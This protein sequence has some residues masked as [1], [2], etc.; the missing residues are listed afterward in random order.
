[1]RAVTVEVS[2]SSGVAGMLMAGCRVDVI[3]T[4]RKGDENIARTIV[5][6]VKVQAVD[7]QMKNTAGPNDPRVAPNR[8]VTLV[9]TPKEAE[10]IELASVDSKPRLVL[11]GLNDKSS[12]AS[13]GVSRS[14]LLGDLA[15]PVEVAAT[16]NDGSLDKILSAISSLQPATQPTLSLSPAPQSPQTL[17]S[18]VQIIR[19]GAESMIYY[20]LK[21]SADGSTAM[22]RTDLNLDPTQTPSK[23]E[24]PVR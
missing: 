18:G 6:N 17:R 14:E 10:A 13:A 19:G 12:S 20:E 21:K 16:P 9:V 7:R 8:T 24:A 22:Q 11:R 23:G 3:A 15:Q 2:E 5:E 1:M 4:L